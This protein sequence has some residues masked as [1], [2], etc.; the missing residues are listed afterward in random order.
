MIFL[1]LNVFYRKTTKQSGFVFG[2]FLVL[3]FSARFAV[4][5]FKVDQVSFESGM[6]LNMGQLLSIPFIAAGVFLMAW[7][8]KTDE[9]AN[10]SIPQRAS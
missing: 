10:D 8:V 2:L 9:P 7:K 4:E 5:F 3:M 1:F 6:A